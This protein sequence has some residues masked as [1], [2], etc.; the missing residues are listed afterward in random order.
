MEHEPTRNLTQLFDQKEFN[1]L[2]RD[3]NLSKNEIEILGPRLKGRNL[4]EK[5]VKISLF[6]NR[7]KHLTRYFFSQNT[8]TYCNDVDGLMRAIG[9]E[10]ITVAFCAPGTAEHDT[11]IIMLKF[12]Q[13]VRRKNL[14]R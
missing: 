13:R 10:R 1:D 14:E 8:L 11:N 2:T 9:H 6:R 5:D 7:E 12:G 3:L 4:L